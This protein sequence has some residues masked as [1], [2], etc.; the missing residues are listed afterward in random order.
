MNPHLLI[1]TI[2]LFFIVVF[3]GLSLLRREGLSTQFA[4]EVLGMTVLTALVAYLTNIPVNPLLFLVI[5]YLILFRGRILTDLASM[6]SNQGRQKYAI[7]L[8]QFA[9]KLHPD[10][11]TRI[12]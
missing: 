6:L 1:L 4:Y 12:S 7:N 8:L 9:L 3:G 10:R 5:I 11:S 2:G